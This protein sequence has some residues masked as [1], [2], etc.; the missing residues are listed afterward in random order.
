MAM[1]KR[2]MYQLGNCKC[3]TASKNNDKS[4][5]PPSQKFLDEAMSR[6]DSAHWVTAWDDEFIRHD[7][8]LNCSL[9][10]KS[11]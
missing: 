4:L 3:S 10:S 8:E 1:P 6:S 5:P 7:T 11:R 2:T 9:D